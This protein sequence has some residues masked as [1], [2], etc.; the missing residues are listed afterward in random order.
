[1]VASPTSRWVV[2]RSESSDDPTSGPRRT[3]EPFGAECARRDRSRDAKSLEGDAPR[4]AETHCVRD[5]G[6]RVGREW[7]WTS[8]GALMVECRQP[9]P[10]DATALRPRVER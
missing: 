4:R 1:M 5:T 9:S 3:N 10:V 2:T 6:A 7:G 8:E